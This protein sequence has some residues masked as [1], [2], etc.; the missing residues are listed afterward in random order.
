MSSQRSNCPLR[1]QEL[2]DKYFIENRTRLLEIAAF[3]DRIDRV[4]SAESAPDFRMRAFAA[5]LEILLG[6][7]KTRVTEIQ[8]LLSDPSTK[9]LEQLDRKSAMGAYDRWSGEALL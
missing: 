8:M 6:D 4:K 1:P 3:L 9:P 5:A 2:V 7:S